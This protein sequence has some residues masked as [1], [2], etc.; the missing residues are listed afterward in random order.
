MQ[1]TLLNKILQYLTEVYSTCMLESDLKQIMLQVTKPKNVT[2]LA[3]V[4]G[5]TNGV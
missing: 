5:A 3:S 2:K 4:N 1:V